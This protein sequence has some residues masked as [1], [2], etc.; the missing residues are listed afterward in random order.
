MSPCS[1]CLSMKR[2]AYL[3]IKVEFMFCKGLGVCEMLPHERSGM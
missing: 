2:A 3:W 1:H